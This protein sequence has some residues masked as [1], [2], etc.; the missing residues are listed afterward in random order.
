M[1]QDEIQMK[2]LGSLTKGNR[3]H[4]FASGDLL[5]EK[6]RIG[7]SATPIRNL[8]RYEIH[9][10]GT[11]PQRIQKKP[12]RGR[13][14]VGVMAQDPEL[15][16]P[17]PITLLSCRV[18]VQLT[19]G[20]VFHGTRVQRRTAP[21][22]LPIKPK[23]MITPINT[24][25]NPLKDDTPPKRLDSPAIPKGCGGKEQQAKN[26]KHWVG[27]TGATEGLKDE[28]AVDYP[29]QHQNKAWGQQAN[30]RQK[31]HR[32]AGTLSHP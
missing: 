3:I 22:P 25:N 21:R 2:V 4:A 29:H 13:C 18:G 16:S 9:V 8:D 24:T 15:L 11:V 17:N 20:A 27:N 10:A 26:R 1:A 19:D 14:W 31:T 30:R 32:R 5:H 28:A 12:T 7:D 23:S 6:T